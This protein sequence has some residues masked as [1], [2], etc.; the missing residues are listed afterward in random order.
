MWT[1]P[2]F[3]VFLSIFCITA[4][5][6]LLGITNVIKGIDKKYLNALFAALILEVVASIIFMFNTQIGKTE[7]KAKEPPKKTITKPEGEDN[8]DNQ[9]TTPSTNP[10]KTLL[11]SQEL[12]PNEEMSCPDEGSPCYLSEGRITRA[13]AKY[14]TYNSGNPSFLLELNYDAYSDTMV[15]LD[16]NEKSVLFN[17]GN[18]QFEIML[19]KFTNGGQKV[20]VQLFEIVGDS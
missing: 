10:T 14:E 4:A 19:K 13:Y 18:K 20:E 11:F 15:V 6:T 8:P 3:I 7:G 1:N 9:H 12:M 2:L 5:I 16:S 17:G